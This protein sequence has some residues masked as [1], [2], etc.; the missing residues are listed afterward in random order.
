MN[1]AV[2]NSRSV[3]FKNNYSPNGG[4]GET[5]ESKMFHEKYI[6]R[7]DNGTYD[8]TLNASGT[9][10]SDVK[11]AFVDIV[12]VVDTSGSMKGS[13]LTSTKNAI[14]ALVDAFDAKKETV[15]TKYK[16]VTFSSSA[17]TKTDN[18]VDGKK[19]KKKAGELSADGGTN[20]DQGL[21]QAATAI[22]S[23]NRENAKKMVIFLTDGKPTF[24]GTKPYGYG[25]ETSKKNA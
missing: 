3:E 23:S 18:W 12:L 25:D 22:N 17:E 8:I 7:N 16:L 14:N 24:Y 9:I 21:S 15:D 11:K 6:K 13:N 19:L 4:S 20:Y 1:I 2:G 5:V 10:G